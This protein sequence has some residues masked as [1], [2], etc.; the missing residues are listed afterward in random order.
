MTNDTMNE[1][2]S[3][4]LFDDYVMPQVEGLIVCSRCISSANW[5]CRNQNTLLL[6]HHTMSYNSRI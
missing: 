1:V 2:C 5:L 3:T 4:D 6:D